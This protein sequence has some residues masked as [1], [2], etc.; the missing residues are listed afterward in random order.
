MNSKALSVTDHNST[1][2][3][4]AAEWQAMR[5]MATALVR[6]GFLPKAIKT[7]EQAIAIILSGNELGL[8]PMQSLRSIHIVEG[9]PTMGAELMMALALR[10]VP[11]G[12]MM[13][14][15]STNEACVVSAGRTR[16][17]AIEY[18]FTIDDAKRAGL[19]NKNNWR[20]YPRAML[21][22][23]V[24]SEAVKAV[25]PDALINAYTTEELGAEN[26][27][28][29]GGPDMDAVV[30]DTHE[31]PDPFYEQI[32]ACDSQDDLDELALRL[33]SRHFSAEDHRHLKD[34]WATR[35]KDVNPSHARK[36]AARKKAA[37]KKAATKKEPSTPAA[38][39]KMREPGADENVR[40]EPEETPRTDET[41]DGVFDDEGEY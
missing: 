37:R 22:S 31:N 41:Q 11:G 19:M 33:K 23:R 5:E 15:E 7:P 27:A 40:Y 34:A 2:V 38:T 1:P 20:N 12:H 25:F 8:G 26:T 29:D 3:I 9:K 17:D 21:R 4:G 39:E 18:S 30:T 16:G 36:K 24:V 28:E 13:I 35:R 6:S 32:L 14:V 10:N